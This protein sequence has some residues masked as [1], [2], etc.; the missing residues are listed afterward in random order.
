MSVQNAAVATHA[1]SLP[2]G[3]SVRTAAGA[4]VRAPVRAPAAA[5]R[6]ADVERRIARRIGCGGLDLTASCG[7][8]TA[9]PGDELVVPPDAQ[10]TVSATVAGTPGSTL[11]IVTAAG[12][13]ARTTVDRSGVR[14]LCWTA[15][16]SSA[17]FARAEVRRTTYARVL[18]PMVAMTNPIWLADAFHMAAGRLGGPRGPLR[19]TP[20]EYW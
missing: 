10:V 11:A 2:A 20:C 6:S 1:R 16:G 4:P 18:A 5:A 15:A 19:S 14:R 12:V 8:D 7:G 3:A 13:A 17:R 9:G